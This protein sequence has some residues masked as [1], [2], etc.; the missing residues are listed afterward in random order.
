MTI[1]KGIIEDAK[2]ILT[3][4]CCQH[5]VRESLRNHG[6]GA[7][8]RHGIYKERLSDMVA[9]SMR[10][11]LLESKGYKVSLFEYVPA[12]ETP[13]NIMLSA[14]KIGTVS[15][16]KSEEKMQEYN[17]LHDVFNT[18]PCLNAFVEKRSTHLITKDPI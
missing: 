17:K 18:E 12:S 13:K 14:N 4:S 7:M 9:D 1:A 8:T 6:L 11:L 2:F 3:V 10:T 15:P 5:T 16:R